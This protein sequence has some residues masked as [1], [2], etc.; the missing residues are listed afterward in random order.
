[1]S[2]STDCLRFLRQLADHLSDAE[3]G[4]SS[5]HAL[6]CASCAARLQRARR[7]GSLLRQRP[8]VPESLRSRQSFERLAESIS[9][10]FGSSPL[11]RALRM[12]EVLPDQGGTRPE[13]VVGEARDV[14][15]DAMAERVVADLS[16]PSQAPG[17]LWLRTR[18]QIRKDLRARAVRRWAGRIAA[19]G[20]AASLFAVLFGWVPLRKGT[21]ELVEIVI[22]PVSNSQLPGLE[23]SPVALLRLAA[24]G[25]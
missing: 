17:W 7:I 10:A 21:D 11:A 13:A 25:H 14:L 18:N 19:V 22:V 16:T 5:G 15:P 1:V 8:P 12:R 3:N 9:D 2:S 24:L 20:V 23:Q 4:A 6:I